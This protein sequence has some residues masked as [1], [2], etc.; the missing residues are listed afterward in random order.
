MAGINH[1]ANYNKQ[2][3]ETTAQ[4]QLTSDRSQFMASTTKSK[5]RSTLL[6]NELANTE[7]RNTHANFANQCVASK[8][9]HKHTQTQFT[10]VIK[11]SMKLQK[12]F[13][14]CN[15][16]A[17]LS[18][19][20]KKI[21]IGSLTVFVKKQ[22]LPDSTWLLLKKLNKGWKLFKRLSRSIYFRTCSCLS[23]V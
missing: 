22:A 11:C 19:R 1:H 17:H 9:K 15:V 2:Q 23:E 4:K 8:P 16:T 14:V 6:S 12:E 20:K 7:L 3:R 21:K 13:C 18:K 10:H 5:R